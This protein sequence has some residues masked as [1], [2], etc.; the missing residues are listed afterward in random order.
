MFADWINKM[1][2]DNIIRNPAIAG[3]RHSSKTSIR[4][5]VI[6]NE[7]ARTASR[8]RSQW[9]TTDFASMASMTANHLWYSRGRE[10]RFAGLFESEYILHKYIMCQA[11]SRLSVYIHSEFLFSVTPLLLYYCII[12]NEQSNTITYS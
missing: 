7:L 4:D 6:F 5:R 9:L 12:I 3:V 11:E 2:I 8:Y 10:K 1:C